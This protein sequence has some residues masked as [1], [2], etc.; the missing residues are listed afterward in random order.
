VKQ[1]RVRYVVEHLALI[2]AK[3]Q[4]MLSKDPESVEGLRT[5]AAMSEWAY[6]AIANAPYKIDGPD[7]ERLSDVAAQGRECVSRFPGIG[8]GV[9]AELDTILARFGIAWNPRPRPFAYRT[10]ENRHPLLKLWDKDREWSERQ[11]SNAQF[12]SDIVRR[13]GQIERAVGTAVLRDTP[14]RDSMQG[15]AYRLSFLTGYLEARADLDRKT[16]D[17]TPEP[18]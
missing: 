11:D 10:D 13:V 6:S 12:W 2:H 14:G 16:I 5:T 1:Q 15:I 3:G 7:M 18:E 8:P 9:M 4:A 17:I